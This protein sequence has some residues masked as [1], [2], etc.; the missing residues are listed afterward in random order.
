M[1]NV[2]FWF[3][4]SIIAMNAILNIGLVKLYMEFRMLHNKFD[5]HAATMND[6]TDILRH[7][8]DYGLGTER[9]K[10]DIGS[11]EDNLN[12]LVRVVETLAVELKRDREELIRLLRDK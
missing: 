6:I 2:E 9:I 5:G 10:E 3:L 8:I 1:D 7:P 12:R 4:T 11:I